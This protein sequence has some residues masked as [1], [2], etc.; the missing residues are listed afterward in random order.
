M[1]AEEN[2]P[3]VDNSKVIHILFHKK[4]FRKHCGKM[5]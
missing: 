3:A 4:M 1:H 5:L 2:D